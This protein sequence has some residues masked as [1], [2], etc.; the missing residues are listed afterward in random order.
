MWRS[1]VDRLA[2]WRSTRQLGWPRWPVPGRYWSPAPLTISSMDRVWCW[3]HVASTSSRVFAAPA[4]SSRCADSCQRIWRSG[5]AHERQW[6]SRAPGAIAAHASRHRQLVHPRRGLV[7][8]L[9]LDAWRQACEATFL[10]LLHARIETC[11]VREVGLEHQVVLADPLDRRSRIAL[12]PVRAVDLAP[13]VLGRAKLQVVDTVLDEL[14]I[15]ALEHERQPADAAL[16]RDEVEA[17]EAVEQ[18]ARDQV[19]D[20]HQVAH[21]RH[22]RERRERAGRRVRAPQPDR[23]AAAPDV[24]VHRR[25]ARLR[26][27]PERIPARVRERLELPGLREVGDGDAGEPQLVLRARELL[28]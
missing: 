4:R 25:A 7:E 15:E 8:E 13:E 24:E 19:Y 10:R 2:A 26:G 1:A 22:R 3:T 9:A 23:P 6:R 11:G 17:R 18:A 21:L 5:E 27:V 12:E 20:A 28:H 16:H 14:I